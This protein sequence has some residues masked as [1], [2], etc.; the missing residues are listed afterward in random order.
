MVQAILTNG[1]ATKKTTPYRS[2]SALRNHY[3]ALL[4]WLQC[5]G[6]GDFAPPK[7]VGLCSCYSGEGVSTVAANLA[8]VAAGRVPGRVLLVDANVTKPSMH[9]RFETPLGPGMT[10]I[11]AGRFSPTECECATSFENLFVIPAGTEDDK[12]CPRYGPAM[13]AALMDEI[14]RDCELAIFDLPP[15]NELSTCYAIASRLDGVLLLLESERVQDKVAQRT[16]RQLESTHANVI[17]VVLNKQ[18]SARFG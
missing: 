18:R 13:V 4:R 3:E 1:H 8:V 14:R 12:D 7:T 15:A 2:R 11:L 5:Y 6:N 17:G 16:K 9:E 10:D